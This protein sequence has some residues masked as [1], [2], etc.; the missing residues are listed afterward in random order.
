[1]RMEKNTIM[2]LV[3]VVLIVVKLQNIQIPFVLVDVTEIQTIQNPY[4][5][6]GCN[7]TTKYTECI[8]III[9]MRYH[10]FTYQKG[11]IDIN[12]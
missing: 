2:F 9:I 5:I 1:M 10:Y 12:Y 6:G 7:K 3:D 8:I 11:H 4:I